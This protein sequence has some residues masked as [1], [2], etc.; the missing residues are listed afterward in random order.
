MGLYN[1][2]YRLDLDDVIQNRPAL[3]VPLHVQQIGEAGN[4]LHRDTAS[5]QGSPCQYHEAP[6][7]W[8]AEEFF[9][10]P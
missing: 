10:E 7:Q 9:H 2:R 8:R 6:M 4:N 5:K 3:V 1:D